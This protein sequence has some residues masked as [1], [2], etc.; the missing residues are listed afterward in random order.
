M[1]KAAATPTATDIADNFNTAEVTHKG[2]TYSFRE[3][4]AEEYDH[5]VELATS[6]DLDA[7]G[8]KKLDTVQLL[9]WMIVQG[10]VEP[11]LNPASLGKLPF[12]ATTKISR[13]VNDLHFRP[14]DDEAVKACVNEE[15]DKT[16]LMADAAFCPKCGKAQPPETDDDGNELLPN[17]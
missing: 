4:S 17:S 6:D 11:K 1:A 2:T 10:S 14:D 8:N 15:C 13:T 5:A 9:R 12:S 3:L 7:D 16:D